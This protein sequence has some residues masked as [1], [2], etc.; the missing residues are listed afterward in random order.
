ML[1]HVKSFPLLKIG[2][3]DDPRWIHPGKQ[4][5]LLESKHEGTEKLALQRALQEGV[6][7]REAWSLWSTWEV[8]MVSICINGI[9]IGYPNGRIMG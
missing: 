8:E 2:P 6:F 1:D 5:A 7:G 3:A 4:I 9:R